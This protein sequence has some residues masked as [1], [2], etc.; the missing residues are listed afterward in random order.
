MNQLLLNIKFYLPIGKINFSN[1]SIVICNLSKYNTSYKCILR[2]LKIALK[3]KLFNLRNKFNS[4]KST[5]KRS[6][7][8][9][10]S[11]HS[12][13]KGLVWFGL[14][15]LSVNIKNKM[16]NKIIIAKLFNIRSNLIINSLEYIKFLYYIKSLSCK[17]YMKLILTN[18]LGSVYIPNTNKNILLTNKKHNNVRLIY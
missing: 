3:K 8:Y 10:F 13:R 15:R 12:V 17:K 11:S 6:K 16:Y 7:T 5:N 1:Y 14:R 9:H 18:I 4:T 2:Y